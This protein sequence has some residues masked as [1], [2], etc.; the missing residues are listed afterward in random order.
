M[1]YLSLRIPGFDEGPSGE[2]IFIPNP[3]GLFQQYASDPNRFT[4]GFILAQL[5]IIA[6]YIAGFLTF[7]YLIWGSFQ[8]ILSSGNKEQLQKARARITWA[9]V[10]L[11]VIFLSYFIAKYA[12]EIFPISKGGLPF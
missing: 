9:L 4:L 12:L 3:S 7:Y 6:F 5:I 8:Y 10:G 11:I 2:D 1:K